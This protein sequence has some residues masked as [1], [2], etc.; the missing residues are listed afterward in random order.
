MSILRV[1]AAIILGVALIILALWGID[2]IF[3]GLFFGSPSQPFQG[4][5]PNV[6]SSDFLIKA[7]ISSAVLFLGIFLVAFNTIKLIERKKK[8]K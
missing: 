4:A 3:L 2:Y 1:L 6:T 8:N 7:L 5:I